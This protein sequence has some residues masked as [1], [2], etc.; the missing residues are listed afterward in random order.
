MIR[1][2]AGIFYLL[3]SGN[4]A[5]STPIINVP[6][7][8][9]ESKQQPTVKRLPTVDVQ[10]FLRRSARNASFTTPLTFGFN[11]H[12]R[13]PRM[14]QWNFAIQREM[15]IHWL[16]R[17]HMSAARVPSSNDIL[18]DKPR[19]RECDRSPSFPAATAIAAFR[20][21]HVL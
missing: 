7:I 8:V 9:D 4:N 17:S 10:N 3:T 12:M 5:V 13:T 16:S 15:T 19:S 18:A 6:F 21:R 11:S 20:N 2:G 1:S 14:Y